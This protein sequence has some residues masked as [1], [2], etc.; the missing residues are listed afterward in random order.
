MKEMDL[1]TQTRSLSKLAKSVPAYFIQMT[2]PLKPIHVAGKAP[3]I[4]WLETLSSRAKELIERE[5]YVEVRLKHLI[6]IKER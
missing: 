5:E 2:P 4:L 3:A 6:L 1:G